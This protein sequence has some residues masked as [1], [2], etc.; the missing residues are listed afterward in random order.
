MRHNNAGVALSA[1]LPLT[2]APG[3]AV[4]TLIAVGMRLYFL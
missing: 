3:R 4:L 2:N 1:V